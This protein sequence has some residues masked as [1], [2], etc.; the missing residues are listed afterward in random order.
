[1][2]KSVPTTGKEA[3]RSGEP[4]PEGSAAAGTAG[5]SADGELRR[6]WAYAAYAG[7]VSAC[8]L[9]ESTALQ[10]LMSPTT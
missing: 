10:F 1:M 7:I 3:L 4:A 9:N 6:T 8:L 5:R 2:R